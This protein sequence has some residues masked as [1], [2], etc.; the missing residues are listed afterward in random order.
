[1]S[2]H[3][4]A[5]GHIA[6]QADNQCKNV[7]G[8]G[9]VIELEALYLIFVSLSV[10]G[11]HIVGLRFLPRRRRLRAKSF[12][13]Q[14]RLAKIFRFSESANQLYIYLHPA[15]QKGRFAVV[16]NAAWDAVDADRA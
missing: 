6:K 7:H 8:I 13:C 3:N 10:S 14:S 12:A 15:P 2:P 4:R 5:H 1:M 11:Q 9:D 16:T